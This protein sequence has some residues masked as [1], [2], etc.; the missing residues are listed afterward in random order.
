MKSSK[1]VVKCGVLV[2]GA[3]VW[4]ILAATGLAAWVGQDIGP[5]LDPPLPPGSSTG[6]PPGAVTVSGGGADIWNATDQFFYY[7]WDTPVTDA[8]YM[9]TARLTSMTGTNAGQTWQ[10]AGL[11]FRNDLSEGSIY[12]F[13]AMSSGNGYGFQARPTALSA[14]G[15]ITDMQTGIAAPN[16]GAVP[17]VAPLWVRLVRTDGTTFASFRSTDG[18]TWTQ[19]GSPHTLANWTDPNAYLGIAVTSHDQNQTTTAI[20]DNVSFNAIDSLVWNDTAGDWGDRDR[21]STRLNSSH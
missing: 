3:A 13:S 6:S 12:A 2:L 1:L 8:D 19:T 18:V 14:T 9:I 11:M 16:P 10:K 7:Y 15:L 4:S 17:P 21:K 5:L 20:F